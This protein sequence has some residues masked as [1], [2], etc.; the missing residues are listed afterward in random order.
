MSHP[1]RPNILF[2]MTD[3]HRFDCVGANGNRLIDTP[4]LDALAEESAN[5][6]SCY[7]QA[8]VCV[9]SRQTFF[10]GRYPRSHKNRVNYTPLNSSETLLQQHLKNESYQTGFVGKLHYWPPSRESALSTGFD[11][12]LIHD[13]G[14]T[15]SNSDYVKWLES[16]APQFADSYRECA[17]PTPD[18]N[19]FTAA[20]PN[21][22]HETTWCGEHTRGMMEQFAQQQK[23]FFLFSSYWRPH[24]PFE[25]PKPWAS[26]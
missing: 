17:S 18:G 1:D 19:P 11:M 23:P 20:I 16:T 4:N 14:P 15:D 13:A 25:V 10:T 12:G 22:Y 5:F 6:T 8:P 9:P 26:K 21:S 2:I 7:V 3:Q 24:S